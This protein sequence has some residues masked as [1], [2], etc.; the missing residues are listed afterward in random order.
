MILCN[1]FSI[2]MFPQLVERLVRFTPVPL[3]QA[4]QI[5]AGFSDDLLAAIGHVSTA[6]IVND[7]LGISVKHDRMDVVFGCDEILLVAQYTGPR[8][9]EGATVLPEGAAINFWLVEEVNA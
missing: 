6:N 8:L 7:L 1:A 5:A 4:R 2:N 3:E 9:S